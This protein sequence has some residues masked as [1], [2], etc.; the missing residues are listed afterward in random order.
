MDA[1]VK[2]CRRAL[3]A[4][5]RHAAAKATCEDSLGEML[6][7]MAYFLDVKKKLNRVDLSKKE[8]LG[9]MFFFVRNIVVNSSFCLFRSRSRR[10]APH[11][12]RPFGWQ[13]YLLYIALMTRKSKCCQA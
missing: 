12:A 13:Y 11:P 9:G 10:C 4:M 8:R 3:K 5:Q 7:R 2:S 6:K 1:A